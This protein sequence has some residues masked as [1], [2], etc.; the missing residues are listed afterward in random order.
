MAGGRRAGGGRRRASPRAIRAARRPAAGLRPSRAQAARPAGRADPR[1]RRRARRRAGRTSLLARHLRDAAAAAWGQPLTMNV[2]MPIAAVMLDL[3][4]PVRRRQGH[5]DPRAHRRPARAPGRGA[6]AARSASSWPGSA[7]EAIAYER[8]ARRDAPSAVEARPWDEQLALDDAPTAPSSRTSSSARA[9]Y[10]DKL[11]AAGVDS[12]RA[13][14]GLADIAAL[15]ADR[16]A[17]A[18]GDV[19]ARRPDRR[20]PLRDAAGDRPDLLHERH[21]RHAELRPADGRRPRE[22]GDRL[23]AQLRGVRRAPPASASSRPTTPGPS[24]P[25]RRSPRS[26][27][28]ASATSRSA[29]A[30]PSA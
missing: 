24:P 9:F 21:D 2:S 15:P 17:R 28:S 23:G 1:A 12:A 18:Q 27:A 26:S 22:L 5:P 29:P 8:A 30:T 20:A 13:A 11:A 4:L 16:E 3:G 25:A 6:R 19:H 10:R 7:E 14:G